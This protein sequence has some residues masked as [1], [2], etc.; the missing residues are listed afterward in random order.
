[1][2][3]VKGGDTIINEKYIRWVKK[4]HDCY[5]VCCKTNGCTKEN[6]IKICKT[7]PESYTKLDWYFNETN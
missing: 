4:I 2:K 1:M 6:T 7:N 5:H 3:F